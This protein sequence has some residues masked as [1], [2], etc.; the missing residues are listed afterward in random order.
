VESE[1]MTVAEAAK[2]LGIGR[3]KA[4]ELVAAGE[5][6]T[7]RIGRAVRVPRGALRAW[8]D[9]QTG[10]PRVVRHTEG[11]GVRRTVR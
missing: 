6:P 11:P 10:E 8:I 2:A 5:I 7:L 1:L 3:T 9:A 4:Y